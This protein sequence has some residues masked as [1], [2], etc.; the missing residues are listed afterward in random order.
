MPEIKQIHRSLYVIVAVFACIY[1]LISLVNH[2]E[3]RTGAYDLGI[4][5]NAIFDYAHLR[6][7]STILFEPLFRPRNALA[8]HFDLMLVLLSPLYW[9]F[10]SWTL[11]I[12]QI[13]FILFGGFG[14]YKL[15]EHISGSSKLAVFALFHFYSI[16]GIYSALS[17]DY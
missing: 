8:D 14:M 10:G 2:Y 12:M 4:F 15:I 7:N 11:L 13:V 17:L 9:L 3:F 6:S 1:G 16:W 5:N